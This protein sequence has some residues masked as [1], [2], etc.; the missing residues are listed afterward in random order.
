MNYIYKL[1]IIILIVYIL[2]NCFRTR[3]G[4]VINSNLK[5]NK[6][7]KDLRTN[8]I[9]KLLIGLKDNRINIT[10]YDYNN[11]NLC[12]TNN[13]FYYTPDNNYIQD[14][15]TNINK[16]KGNEEYNNLPNVNNINLNQNKSMNINSLVDS[17]NC[18]IL[19]KTI[20]NPVGYNNDNVSNDDIQKEYI[21][22]KYTLTEHMI[23]GSY[24]SSCVYL[25][26]T[27]DVH[28]LSQI[29]FLFNLGVR[30]FDF[31][32][33]TKNNEYYIVSPL[34]KNGLTVSEI[35]GD[36]LTVDDV[37]Y[38]VS[39]NLKNP[40]FST[41]FKDLMKN[42][43]PGSIN[44]DDPVIININICFNDFIKEKYDDIYNRIV[45][46]IPENIIYTDKSVF[47]IYNNN[48]KDNLLHEPINKF[49]GKVIIFIDIY[50]NYIKLNKDKINLSPIFDQFIKSKLSK[51]VSM[52]N[53]N[54][55]YSNLLKSL[56]KKQELLNFK[57]IIKEN[58]SNYSMGRDENEFSI[59][60]PEYPTKCLKQN[61]NNT[62]VCKGKDYVNNG[63][64]IV[65]YPFYVLSGNDKETDD[66]FL[67]Y[68]MCFNDP[69][70]YLE[71]KELK[72]GAILLKNK[73]YFSNLGECHVN[74]KPEDVNA[75]SNIS[76]KQIKNTTLINSNNNNSKH[77][78][79]NTHSGQQTKNYFLYTI[80]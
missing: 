66:E 30:Y 40:L 8:Y 51:I 73:D 10:N 24:N 67:R 17:M 61:R 9:L 55:E 16:I 49:K 1:L 13:Y 58:T 15:K 62:Y 75:N 31:N 74:V 79:V 72:P 50:S 53:V 54:N 45:K 21:N 28:D 22:N 29:S 52:V 7:G 68:Y 44:N 43:Q 14:C 11:S 63:V 76:S 2:Y 5:Q 6:K 3:E 34:T 26:N 59:L 57:S 19:S 56:K 47:N 77:Q 70:L 36:T 42:I 27:N 71:N 80:K 33:V 18:H 38:T 41:N 60:Y 25:D 32:I 46:Y 4:L 65:S 12:R 20:G 69:A 64:N 35:S 78:K 48:A 23:L 37:M 39:E